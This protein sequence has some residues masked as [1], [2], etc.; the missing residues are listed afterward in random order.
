MNDMYFDMV[1]DY[2][3]GVC[4]EEEKESF[5]SHIKECK[6]CREEYELA[7]SL[8]NVLSSMPGIEPPAD[9]LDKLND[10]LD[11]E[12]MRDEKKRSFRIPV[13]RYSAVAAC[14]VLVAV[15]GV[16]MVRLTDCTSTDNVPIPTAAEVQTEQP[17]ETPIVDNISAEEQ[18]TP[19]PAYE[20]PQKKIAD[21]A[22]KNDKKKSASASVPKNTSKPAPIASAAVNTATPAAPATETS[23]P[24][25]TAAAEETEM[26]KGVPSYMDP[27]KQVVLASSVENEFKVS[28]VS[29]EDIPVKKRDLSAEFAL[30]ESASNS[31]T[32]SIIAT[33]VTLASLDE[34]GVEKIEDSR[35]GED[36]YEVGRGSMFISSKDKE[37]VSAL[38]QKYVSDES[39]QYYYFTGDNFKSFTD[40]L[41]ES[42]ISY[43]KYR[44]SQDGSNV[45]FQVVY[46]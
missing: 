9:F 11:S 13:R 28:G 25:A 17:S 24:E 16:D 43:Q 18:S 4:S 37:A 19:L 23:K 32:G 21:K 44:I 46:P 35:R 6:K 41:N 36:K 8:K 3:S 2:I 12:L 34:I 45:A 7:M 40:E 1:D 5:E 30:L 14:F 27:R 20:N 39:E 10:R 31:K 42:G 22:K 33:P 26:P 29:I 15:L 38:I